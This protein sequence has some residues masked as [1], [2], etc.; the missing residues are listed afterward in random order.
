LRFR[1][2]VT[3]ND[4]F[5]FLRR[6]E[7]IDEVNFWLPSDRN[8]FRALEPGELFLFKLH[9]PLNYVVGGGIFVKYTR[10]PYRWVWNTFGPKN[11]AATLDEMKRRIERYR[12]API[13]PNDSIGCILL[14]QPFFWHEPQWIPVPEDFAR[15]IVQG[16]NY[17]SDSPTA[18]SL[19]DQVGLRLKVPSAEIAAPRGMYGEPRLVRSRLG[20]GSFRALVT[21][22]YLRR[23]AVTGEKALPV[24]EAAH[25]R[26]VAEGGEHRIDNGLL[27]RADVHLLFDAGY[28]TIDSAGRF[29]VSRRLKDDFDDGEPYLPFHGNRIWLPGDPKSQPDL[30]ALEWHSEHVFLG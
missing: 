1:I 8:T 17:E 6:Q 24:L 2:A 16:K 23:C 4:W 11:G 21:D 13:G 25:V 29:L 3:D 18:R 5:T 27:L 14:G 7:G 22:N 9:A 30:Q 28:V 12:R 15:N 19:W 26:P 20:Q 10:F